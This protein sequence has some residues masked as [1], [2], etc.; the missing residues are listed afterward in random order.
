MVDCLR[1]VKRFGQ[2]DYAPEPL[3]GN[4]TEVHVCRINWKFLGWRTGEPRTENREPG[5]GN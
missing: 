1:A 4:Y 3:P 2:Q 5:T